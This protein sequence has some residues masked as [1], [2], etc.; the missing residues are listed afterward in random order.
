MIGFEKWD[1]MRTWFHGSPNRLDVLRPGSTIT[2]DEDL[3]RI[4]SHKPQTVLLEDDPALLAAGAER[5]RHTGSLPGFLHAVDEPVGPDDVYP[6]PSSSM[7]A[8][9]EWLTR[10]P[11]RL[12]LI[13][14]TAVR[15][16]EYL[17]PEGLIAALPL[18]IATGNPS[19]F[20]RY[21]EILAQFP[22]LKVLSPRDLGLSVPVD[23]SG[24]AAAENA[25]FKAEAYLAASGLPALGIDEAL[26]IP[27]LLPEEQPGVMV[28]RFG[29]KSGGALDDEELL[30]AFI[31]VARRLAPSQRA[32]RWTFAVC[33]ALPDG[34]RLAEEAGWDGVLT[35]HPRLPYPPGYPLSAILVDAGT[36]KPVSLM[37][38]AERRQRDLPL[39]A[40]V[41]RLVLAAGMGG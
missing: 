11:L 9:L 3:A 36:G 22:R 26:N 1:F 21:R 18:L 34:R 39:A 24:A 20:N 37:T 15:P 6:H 14:Q 7:A 17:S 19:K 40:A 38:D 32:V 5:L 31:A 27:A 30:Q 12:R 23:E 16:D 13:A 35:D 2:Q 10:R 28:R 4:F 33:L 8:G 29:A 41:R 25:R